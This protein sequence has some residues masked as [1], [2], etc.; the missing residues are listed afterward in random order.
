MSDLMIGHQVELSCNVMLDVHNGIVP[1][2]HWLEKIQ[3]FGF[4]FLLPFAVIFMTL[5]L[6]SIF[7]LRE[8][9]GVGAN[10]IQLTPISPTR[11]YTAA[12]V[13]SVSAI[14]SVLL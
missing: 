6:V 7:G 4:I 9:K 1:T 12:R 10:A 8:S 5:A 13:S 2:V 3:N 14:D 11:S